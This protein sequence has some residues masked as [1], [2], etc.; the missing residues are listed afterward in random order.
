MKSSTHQIQRGFSLV[1][2]VI[3]I[4]VVAVLLSGFLIVFTPAAAGIRA[5]INS[6]KSRRLVATLEQEL[7]TLRGENQKS[8]FATGFN[9]AFEYIKRSGGQSASPDDALLVYKYRASLSST[10]TDG[11]PEPVDTVE[12][13]IAGRDYVMQNMLR[14]KS[15]NQFLVDLP[16]VEG[17]I[18]LVKCT[19]LVLTIDDDED[20]MTLGVPGEIY[21]M[22]PDAPVCPDAQSY[23]ESV[24][25]FVADFYE[26]PTKSVSFFSSETFENIV[27][28]EGKPLFTRN[29]SVRR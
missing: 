5:S 2:T 18:Y 11:T 8:E 14:R 21:Q 22:G 12:D 6:E 13:N 16:A 4:G 23:E 26:I 25:T 7:V 29:L 27:K 24:I 9:K 19:Q 20:M 28:T 1:E 10:R 15:D 3:A 17:P